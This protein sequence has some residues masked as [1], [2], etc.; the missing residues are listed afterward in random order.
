MP[1][2]PNRFVSGGRSAR[3][4]R[5]IRDRLG[6]LG[7]SGR[8]ETDKCNE[9]ETMTG[10]S[11]SQWVRATALTAAITAMLLGVGHWSAVRAQQGRQGQAAQGRGAGGQAGR[12]GGGFSFRHPE[13]ID[14]NNNEGWK[15]L[16]DGKTLKGWEGRTDVWSVEDGAIVGTSTAEKPSGTT[17]LIYRGGQFSDFILKMEVKV[18]SNANGGIQFRSQNVPPR[19]RPAAAAGGGGAGAGGRG[20]QGGGAAQ[21]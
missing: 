3:S 8:R 5:R 7:A 12:G 4:R 20:G 13:P 1:F 16:F 9:E 2:P 21:A 17:N 10:K 18:E 14:F 11:I 19:P 15:S 6:L